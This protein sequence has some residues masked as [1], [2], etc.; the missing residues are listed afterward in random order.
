MKPRDCRQQ[1]LLIGGLTNNSET[2]WGVGAEMSCVHEETNRVWFL[3][4]FYL[5]VN[6][7][8][9]EPLRTH[10]NIRDVSTV[11]NPNLAAL[12]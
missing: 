2:T 1:V 10:L 11:E 7:I 5:D 8:N 12:I 3:A 6:F 4:P 9:D